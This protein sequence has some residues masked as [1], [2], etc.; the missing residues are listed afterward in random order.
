MLNFSKSRILSFKYAFSGLLT[1][2]KEEPN[3][4]IHFVT[5]ILVLLAG[6][7]LGLS[8]TDWV[9]VILLIGFVITLELTNTAIEVVV[10]S[11]TSEVHP[12]AKFA[13]DVAASAVLV[14]AITAA[15]V[16]III[17]LPYL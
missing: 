13:K 6:A 9:L 5:A 16:G 3:L 11:F 2:L 10:D 7:I 14:G 4:K 12:A 15:T 1:A 17:F 8:K